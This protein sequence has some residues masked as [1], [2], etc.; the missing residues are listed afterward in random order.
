MVE[1]CVRDAEVGGSN[2]LTPTTL[3]LRVVFPTPSEAQG[4]GMALSGVG[5]G[6]GPA[7][8]IGPRSPSMTLGAWSSPL[9]SAVLAI[10]GQ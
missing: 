9:E 5:R 2:P 4:A 7:R 3:P 10:T 6:G 8:R 1:R